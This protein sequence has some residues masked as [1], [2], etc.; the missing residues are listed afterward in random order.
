MKGAV[1]QVGIVLLS[2]QSTEELAAIQQTVLG[3][4]RSAD[5]TALSIREAGDLVLQK[6]HLA[7]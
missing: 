1:G 2:S 6:S 3:N 4:G 7:G 5:P